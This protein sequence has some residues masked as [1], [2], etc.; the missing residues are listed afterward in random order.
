MPIGVPPMPV[1][2]KI[3]RG[4]ELLEVTPEWLQWF[5]TIK[6]AITN[7]NLTVTS[8]TKFSDLNF[9][10]SNLTSILTRNHFDLQSLTVGDDHTMYLFLAGRS[11]GQIAYGGSAPSENLTLGSTADPTKGF[12]Y[13][14]SNSAYNEL[15]TR[16]GIGTP[17]PSCTVEVTSSG[18][19]RLRIVSSADAQTPQ[20]S[21]VNTSGLSGAASIYLRGAGSGDGYVSGSNAAFLHLGSSASEG[22][23]IQTNFSVNGSTRDCTIQLGHLYFGTTNVRDIGDLA[24]TLRPRTGYFGTSLVAP[25][26]NAT[27][28]FQVSGVAVAGTYLRGN[29]TNYVASPILPG[30]IASSIANPI[31]LDDF[32]SE[33]VIIPYAAPSTS[34][35]TNVFTNPTFPLTIEDI[36]SE[37]QIFT[38]STNLTTFI[39]ST[40]PFTIE[41]I[42]AEEQVLA[43]PAGSITNNFVT[44]L[45]GRDIDDTSSEDIQ[46]SPKGSNT[47]FVRPVVSFGP[48]I[49]IDEVN[50]RFG[51]GTPAPSSKWHV[52]N[53]GVGG[54]NVLF[55][56]YNNI[57]GLGFDWT[58]RSSRGTF[59]S[60]S[61]LSSGDVVGR[62]GFDGYSGTGFRGATSMRVEVDAAIT[63]TN[64]VPGRFRWFT[65][66]AAGGVLPERMRLDSAGNLGIG[67]TAAAERNLDVL[68]NINTDSMYLVGGNPLLIPVFL[69][70]SST[71]EYEV[72]PKG[73]DTLFVRPVVKFGPSIAIDEVNTRISIGTN[74][75]LYDFHQ[76]KSGGI[77]TQ[78]QATFETYDSS[79]V[80]LGGSVFNFR[81]GRGTSASPSVVSNGDTI[82]GISFVGYGN[83]TYIQ[84][85]GIKATVGGT[86]AN[87]TIPGQLDFSTHGGNGSSLTTK[88]TIDKA[89]IVS[90][91]GTTGA[92]LV[93]RLTT[94]QKNALTAV[95]GM[96]VYDSTL[97]KFQ[98]Y[99]NGTW[100]SF[101]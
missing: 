85:A 42:S 71:E 76:V 86:F 39:S 16:L 26:V 51:L 81:A 77:G 100:T 19:T 93:H 24:N 90:L 68:G 64:Y 82:A 38:A 69:D 22:G 92:L 96:I 62:W 11:G 7:I 87:D 50:T 88:L 25:L 54:A 43:V 45:S 70:D 75:P 63:D 55:D 74:V 32:S 21:I 46:L 84:L 10:G 101:I 57:S 37:D 40:F 3:V 4:K 79:G 73:G 98:G 31:F 83:T 15:N 8:V 48:S 14:G 27:I 80:L 28:G 95:N 6:N 52:Q 61:A 67:K 2:S 18:S 41:D 5:E 53:E 97:N 58:F 65:T 1:R 66:P 49:V 56:S 20:L 13:F 47:I 35:T 23:A 89:G 78:G 60:P 94:T 30:D 99:E 9:A 36:T 91:S 59:A 72:S 34:T 44:T 12:I 33:D 17:A 29:G